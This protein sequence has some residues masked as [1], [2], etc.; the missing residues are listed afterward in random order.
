MRDDP[1]F[2]M[3]VYIGPFTIILNVADSRPRVFKGMH[4][5][6]AMRGVDRNV[7]MPWEIWR[8]FRGIGAVAVFQSWTGAFQ[9]QILRMFSVTKKRDMK[10]A[11]AKLWP[12]I[13]ILMRPSGS[14]CW[15][16]FPPSCNLKVYFKPTQTGRTVRGILSSRWACAEAAGSSFSDSFSCVSVHSSA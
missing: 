5:L 10:D 1:H 15:M 14:S 3:V 13:A 12:M 7:I 2:S 6:F 16:M 4:K 8:N 11:L 9:N